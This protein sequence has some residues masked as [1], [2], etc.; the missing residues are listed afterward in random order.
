MKV[1]VVTPRELSADQIALWRRFQER[2][3]ALASPYFCPE[4]TQA[5]GDVRGDAFVGVME[6]AGEVIGFFPFQR[7]ALGV[8]KPIGGPLSDYQGVIA[9]GDAEWDGADLVRQCGLCVYDFDHM[10]ASQSGFAPY[11]GA[12][13]YSP[14]IDLSRGFDVYARGRQ[15][16][17]SKV[18]TDNGRKSRKLERE[19]GRV[20]FRMHDNRPETFTALQA[21]KRVQYRETGAYDVFRHRWTIELLERL[22]AIQTDDFAGVFSTLHANEQL[23]SVHL[24]MRSRRVWHYWFPAYDRRFSRYSP[25]IILILKMAAHAPALGIAA[26]DMGWGDTKYKQRLCDGSVPIAVGR[27]EIASPAVGLRRARR[28]TEELFQRLPLGALSAV[29]RKAFYRIERRLNFI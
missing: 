4:F 6:E 17:K 24:G 19:I 3:R 5:V 18:I 16:V 27:V 10:L 28:A 13:T 22:C 29:P 15:G 2:D 7:R 26:I 8:G 12:R 23:V 11:H 21:W 1:H 20:E 9:A 14:V 25:G